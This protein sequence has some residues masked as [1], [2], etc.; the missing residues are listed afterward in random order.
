MILNYM[1]ENKRIRMIKGF[2]KKKSE[3]SFFFQ[4]LKCFVF[5]ERLEDFVV[6]RGQI[7]LLSWTDGLDGLKFFWDF[8][9]FC[10][11]QLIC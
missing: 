7:E 3:E 5:L 6:E 10:V 11:I 2:V 1:W 4:I 9:V 8:S